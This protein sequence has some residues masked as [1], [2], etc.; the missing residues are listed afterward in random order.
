M[1]E[2]NYSMCSIIRLP[3]KNPENKTDAELVA[4]TLENEDN[5]LY[6]INRYEKKLLRYIIRMTALPREDA[7][8]ILQEVFLKI[9]KNLNDFDM[10]LSFSSW[11]YRITHN[12][13]INHAK[14][15]RRQ[16][17]VALE[18]DDDDTVSLIDILR[19]DEDVHNDFAV[20]ELGKDVR[21]VLFALPE[22]Y[23]EVLVLRY[24]EDKDYNEISDILKKPMGTVATLI[25]RAKTQFEIM[26]KRTNINPL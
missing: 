8:D 3:M 24:L 23:R 25:N 10:D 22:K 2:K 18:T 4:L 14:K 5:F 26:A 1:K 11:A 12:E 16:Q 15:I 21:N 7:E 19:S 17:T 6:L 13:S 20:K 9:Y